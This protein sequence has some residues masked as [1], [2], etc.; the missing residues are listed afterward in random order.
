MV[1]LHI[2]A[3]V[4][5]IFIAGCSERASS[6]DPVISSKKVRGRHRYNVYCI[7]SDSDHDSEKSGGDSLMI[8]R[9]RRRR[10]RTT[11]HYTDESDSGTATVESPRPQRRRRHRRPARDPE[12]WLS[13]S[14][15]DLRNEHHR[16]ESPAA[17]STKI[18]TADLP[19]HELLEPPEVRERSQEKP[20]SSTTDERLFDTT[21]SSRGEAGDIVG[22]PANTISGP[23]P[24]PPPAPLHPYVLKKQPVAEK[25]EFDIP[26]GGSPEHIA[27]SKES[28]ATRPKMP[29]LV[30]NHPTDESRNE[31]LQTIKDGAFKLRP[32]G[33]ALR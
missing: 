16:V 31:L 26:V 14:G 10:H 8:G 15:D 24:P 30:A 17:Y 28:S 32:V 25:T 6:N 3:V 20:L 19:C 27:A 33:K 7:P 5:G 1:K 22:K 2:A 29:G 23:P 4:V 11:E 18:G 12:P 21:S 9:L 13:S